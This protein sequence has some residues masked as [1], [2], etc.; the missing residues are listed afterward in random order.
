MRV[1]ALPRALADLQVDA[2]CRMTREGRA[3]R[4]VLRV[5]HA[6]GFRCKWEM[7]ER[8]K[9]GKR[10]YECLWEMPLDDSAPRS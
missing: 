9:R 3:T 7:Q 10:D 6:H 5:A 4:T 1:S 8:C 2:R